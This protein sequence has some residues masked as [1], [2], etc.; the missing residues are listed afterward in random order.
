MENREICIPV[1]NKVITSD[2]S[3]DYTL[4]DYQPE[5]K[6]VLY[7]IANPAQPAKYVN[8]TTV[9]FSGNIEYLIF[10]VG[11][12]GEIYSVPVISEY[13]LEAPID[14]LLS[15][16][17]DGSLIVSADVCA[18]NVLARLIGPRKINV[19]SKIKAYVNGY[20]I[21]PVQN[22]S[23]S[24]KI[25]DSI[26][27]LNDTVFAKSLLHFVS[28]A[29]EISEEIIPEHDSLRIIGANGNIFVT[30]S[31][32]YNDKIG[33][34]GEIYLTLLVSD[35]ENEG[36]VNTIQR[37][38]PIN[39]DLEFEGITPECKCSVYGSI[40]DITVNVLDGRMIC[41][42]SV[43]FITNA[44]KPETLSYTK[45][46]YSTQNECEI[47]YRSYPTITD[48]YCTNGNFSMNERLLKENL[49]IPDSAKI[50]DA[51]GV[52]TA[53]N[54]ET[55]DNKSVI[56]GQVK[57]TLLLE[58]DGEYITNEI[59]LPIRYEFDNEVGELTNA[60]ANVTVISCRAR[61]DAESIS[62]D[63]ELAVSSWG[64]IYNE[65]TAVSEIALGN[66][67]SK[68][69]GEL[70]VYYLRPED[71]AWSIAK[72]YH[73]SRSVLEMKNKK[74]ENVDYVII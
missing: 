27:C 19:K 57:Y 7:V 39:T 10:Y 51:F 25:S 11:A 71:T 52:A 60:H 38:T 26:E 9:E 37:R 23:V 12:D 28:D 48:G 47:N 72:K 17:A 73:V 63:A 2:T 18:E 33:I 31:V 35:T 16:T 64:E 15:D 58:A 45:D 42:S 1:C 30:D 59:V 66:E 54:I 24:E 53:D 62:I 40:N 70:V 56:N 49:S 34:K 14:P 65:I 41:D 22:L 4:P 3:Y 36:N 55:H 68:N 61:Q 21:V 8:T 32:C 5:A 43:S 13:E 46:M 29:I 67:L 6:R 44:Q 50:I 20:Y 74:I 69:K